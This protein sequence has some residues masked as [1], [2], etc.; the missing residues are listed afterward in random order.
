[1]NTLNNDTQDQVIKLNEE[2]VNAGTVRYNG[3]NKTI[4]V[5]Y[6]GTWYTYVSFDPVRSAIIL[7]YPLTSNNSSSVCTVSGS[8][9]LAQAYLAFNTAD[10]VFAVLGNNNP[11]FCT[12]TDTQ[13]VDHIGFDYQ[14]DQAN[15]TLQITTDNINWRTVATLPSSNGT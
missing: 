6:N 13:Y 5:L 11:L 15:N 4:E 2:I 8:S 9:D 12:F 10:N 3:V 14:A 1:M 7:P